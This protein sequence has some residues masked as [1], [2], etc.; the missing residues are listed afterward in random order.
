VL[1]VFREKGSPISARIRLHAPS[2]Y[3][4]LRSSVEAPNLQVIWP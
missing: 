3:D 2:R 1:P 4:E